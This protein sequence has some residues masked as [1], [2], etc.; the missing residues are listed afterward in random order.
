[1]AISSGSDGHVTQVSEVVEF[2]ELSELTLCFE[3]ERISQKQV[4]RMTDSPCGCGSSL[5]D[6]TS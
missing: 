6:I 2:P 5:C 1:M 4:R 3:V